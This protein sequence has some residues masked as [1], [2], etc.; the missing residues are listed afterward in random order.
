MNFDKDEDD[1]DIAIIMMM[2]MMMMTAAMKVHGSRLPL[3]TFQTVFIVCKADDDDDDG[4]ETKATTH[5]LASCCYCFIC[6]SQPP[7]VKSF[8][9]LF[10]SLEKGLHSVSIE[11]GL[12]CNLKKAAASFIAINY[13][14]TTIL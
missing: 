7:I 2:M 12:H 1:N 3:K 9:K 8:D 10:I 5:R 11:A 4:G 14:I 6:L 13:Y